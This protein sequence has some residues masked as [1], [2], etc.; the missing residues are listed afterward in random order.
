M[1]AQAALDRLRAHLGEELHISDWVSVEQDRIDAFA[2]ATLDDQWIHVDPERAAASPLGTTIAHGFLTLS[3][4]PHLARPSLPVE[5]PFDARMRINYGLNKVRF[6]QPVPAGA[7]VRS[8]T[9]IVEADPVGD[10]GV[11]LVR[12]V[13]VEIENAAK[14]ACICEQVVR[15]VY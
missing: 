13:T 5:P 15:L 7:R 4:I 3:L 6:P 10:T 2:D 11:Q 9:T 1:S 8:R 14:P 12:R